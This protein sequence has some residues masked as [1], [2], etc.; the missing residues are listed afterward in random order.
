MILMW[1]IK[2]MKDEL[3]E[4]L[5]EVLELDEGCIDAIN[6]NTNLLDLGVDSLKAIE[7]VVMI[8]DKYGIMISDDDLIVDNF[9]TLEKIEKM[10]STYALSV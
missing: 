5:G 8:E 9:S 3:I 4:I 2:K 6:N 7:I 1:E 10:V